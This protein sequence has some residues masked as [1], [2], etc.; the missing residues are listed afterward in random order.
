MAEMRATWTTMFSRPGPKDGPRRSLGPTLRNARGPEIPIASPDFPMF[1]LQVKYLVKSGKLNP[2]LAIG[3]LG[4]MITATVFSG[5]ACSSSSGEEAT[6][7]VPSAFTSGHDTPTSVLAAPT[8]TMV[9]TMRTI[10]PAPTETAAPTPDLKALRFG[11]EQTMEG[12]V[13]SIKISEKNPSTG[14]NRT[15]ITIDGKPMSFDHAEATGDENEGSDGQ[16]EYPSAGYSFID[17]YN[18]DRHYSVEDSHYYEAAGKVLES[19]MGKR[20]VRMVYS[21]RKPM[22][23]KEIDVLTKIVDS[24]T[25]EILWPPLMFR[26]LA[27]DKD[28]VAYL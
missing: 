19:L 1:A 5:M 2:Y 24:S 14:R 7:T 27:I 28:G 17:I 6:P 26:L 15:E 11:E 13:S 22:L 4:L 3:V 12:I 23:G 8:A 9:P 18:V 16:T 21:H 10:T 25:G 20:N